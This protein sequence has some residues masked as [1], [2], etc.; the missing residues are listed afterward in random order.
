MSKDSTITNRPINDPIHTVYFYYIEY[1][2]DTNHNPTHN[3]SAYYYTNDDVPVTD[4][5]RL[6]DVVT[7][8][9]R[10]AKRHDF[11]PPPFAKSIT[12]DVPLRKR[13]YLAIFAYGGDQGLNDENDVVINFEDREENE[14]HSFF[15]AQMID[16]DLE[17]NGSHELKAFCCTNLML[18]EGG[19]E[20]GIGER[21]PFTIIIHPGG[22]KPMIF[23]GPEGGGTNQ[24]GPIPPIG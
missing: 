14:N 18:K 8:L 21:E 4:G 3:I 7:S 9:A 19:N 10:N 6:C 24:G 17:G 5:Q 23:D 12:K 2:I 20:L 13:S 15:N 11:A 1:G 22:A 16:I